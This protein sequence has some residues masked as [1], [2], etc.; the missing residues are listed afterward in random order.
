MMNDKQV[1]KWLN[2]YLDDV[3]YDDKPGLVRLTFKIWHIWAQITMPQPIWIAQRPDSMRCLKRQVVIAVR[4]EIQKWK[5]E[6]TNE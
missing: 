5:K 1:I 2:R 4:L 6:T 3:A